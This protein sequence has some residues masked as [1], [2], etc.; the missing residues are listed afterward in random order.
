MFSLSIS[1][2]VCAYRY[3]VCDWYY[4][5][6]ILSLAL[7]HYQSGIMH[8]QSNTITLTLVN[9]LEQL[10]QICPTLLGPF[11]PRVP[12]SESSL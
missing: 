12:R 7:Y 9:V 2:N 6:L 1:E 5:S 10:P 8:A 11:C 3:M 4:V